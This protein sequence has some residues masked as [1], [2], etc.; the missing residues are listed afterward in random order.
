MSNTLSGKSGTLATQVSELTARFNAFQSGM[1]GVE[2]Y[3][4]PT[5]V[6]GGVDPAWTPKAGQVLSRAAY[7]AFWE[8]VKKTGAYV[9][10]SEWMAIQGSSPNG[11]VSVYS[12][13]DGSTTFRMPTVGA[14]GGFTRAV[15]T[16]PVLNALRDLEG[17]FLDT[18][19]EHKHAT[20]LTDS[21]TVAGR[22]GVAGDFVNN[23][24]PFGY[25]T[26]G[27]AGGVDY[28]AK[29][30][31]VSGTEGSAIL[32]STISLLSS[33]SVHETNGEVSPK[34]MF[35]KVYVYTGNDTTALPTPTPEWLTQQETNSTRISEVEAKL[36]PEILEMSDTKAIN[37][38]GGSSISGSQVRDLNTVHKNTIPGASLNT[39]TSIFTL[40]AGEYKVTASAPCYAGGR[41]GLS[42]VRTTD[43][44]ELLRGTAEHAYNIQ[45]RSEIVRT[46]VLTEATTLRFVHYTE[47]ATATNGLGVSSTTGVGIFTTA[48]IERIA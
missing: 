24:F 39:S 40:P 34:G 23:N 3:F 22:L 17:G 32:G 42:L 4:P 44:E 30:S 38:N 1:V 21:T 10:D 28:S 7:P 29:Y 25:I 14:D 9:S 13:G 16:D 20:P 19:P 31:Y 43:S 8:W 26:Y 33:A 12:S 2:T 45:S 47:N 5:T 37:V 11:S 48:Y 6:D 35:G 36:V 15:G 46:L 18:F 27:E 41:H